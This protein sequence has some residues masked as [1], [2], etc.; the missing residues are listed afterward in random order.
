MSTESVAKRLVVLCREGMYE[1][2]QRELYSQDAQSIEPEGGPPGSL[3]NVK[4][5]D[6]IFEKGKKF[7]ESVTEVHGGSISDPVVAGNWFSCSMTLDV[8]M[9]EY[10]RVNMTEICVYHVNKE[11]KIDREQ[12]FYDMG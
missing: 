4:G 6:A 7:Q 11:G 8:T 2:A 5:L 9:K 10:G 12:F 1:E 3:G